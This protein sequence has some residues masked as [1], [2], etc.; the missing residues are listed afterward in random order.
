M[1]N[2]G[3]LTPTTVP[4]QNSLEKTQMWIEE[5]DYWQLTRFSLDILGIYLKDIINMKCSLKKLYAI[6]STLFI[7]SE[8]PK[9]VIS[10]TN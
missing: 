4:S 10:V 3:F 8:I 2:H 6:K 7:F 1:D 9:P 5:E